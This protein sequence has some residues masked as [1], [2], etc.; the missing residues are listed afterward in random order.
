MNQPTRGLIARGAGL[1]GAAILAMAEAAEP[2]VDDWPCYGHDAGGRRY[3]PLAQIN[4]ENVIQLKEAW[5]FHTGDI[6]DGKGRRRRSGFET[7][8]LLVDGMLY[9]TTP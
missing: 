7:T 6:S 4:R 8:P 3:S 9:L 5:V 1:A 2:S